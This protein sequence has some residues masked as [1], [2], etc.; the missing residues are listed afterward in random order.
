[1]AP[2]IALCVERARRCRDRPEPRERKHRDRIL[3][4]VRTKDGADIA[5]PDPEPRQ[6]GGRAIDEIREL[7]VGESSARHAVNQRGP[8]STLTCACEDKVS[9]RRVRDLDRR[10]RTAIDHVGLLS[11]CGAPS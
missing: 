2:Q 4:C 6:P 5:F 10:S 3:G 11:V 8:V 9:E 1:M 7:A